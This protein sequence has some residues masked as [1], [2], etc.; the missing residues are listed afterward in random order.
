ML[1]GLIEQN[2]DALI[3]C[4]YGFCSTDSRCKTAITDVVS[5]YSSDNVKTYFTRRLIPRRVIP[6]LQTIV[7]AQKNW[8]M[9]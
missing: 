7:T 3:L 8:K 5:E 9:F 4:T 1:N 2:P 6:T